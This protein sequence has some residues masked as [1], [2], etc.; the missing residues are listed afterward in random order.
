MSRLYKRPDSPYYWW[1]A[2]YRGKRL[3]KSTRM[4]K[5]KLAQQV[6]DHW[7]LKLIKG[8]LDFII[9]DNSNSGSFDQ[10]LK[11]YLAHSESYHSDK[12]FVIIKGMLGKFQ[13][14]CQKGEI[15]MLSDLKTVHIQ[16]HLDNLTCASK[17]RRNHLGEIKRMFDYAIRLDLVQRNPCDIITVRKNRNEP[18]RDHRLL[19]DLDLKLINEYGEPY[20]L[21]Y[22]MLLY[23][24]LRAGDVALLT[25][26]NI[27][28]QKG[29]IESLIRKSRKIHEFPLAAHLLERLNP[30]KPD[31][32]PL[33][34]AVFTD[35]DRSQNDKLVRPR[36]HLQWLLRINN[37][38]KATLHSFRHT[39]NQRLRDL[40]LGIED[41]QALLAHASSST[42]KIYTHPNLD[43]AREYVN[44]LP[45]FD[46][47]KSN[48][49]PA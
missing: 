14:F 27:N 29:C 32:E 24:G 25:Y 18:K 9:I 41:R 2:N 13:S 40:G 35:K 22:D 48:V 44:K 11:N 46:S 16:K 49:T 38:P 43:L 10:F 21:F 36:K 39:F 37:R 47:T 28:F 30:E 31:K 5:K 4:G 8:E 42:T 19:K 34:P 1:S 17:T 12:M 6:K 45:V 20:S 26:G 7:D 33:F 23:T 3:R 15:R